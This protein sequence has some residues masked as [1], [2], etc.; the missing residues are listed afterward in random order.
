MDGSPRKTYTRELPKTRA[1]EIAEEAWN[2]LNEVHNN[3]RTVDAIE[4][5]ILKAQAEWEEGR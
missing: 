5:A 1:R 2:R 3:E 4:S